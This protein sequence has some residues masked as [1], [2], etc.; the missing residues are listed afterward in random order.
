MEKE[1]EKL[2]MRVSA[3]S[4]SIEIWHNWHLLAYLGL[5]S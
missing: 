4:G 3:I 2:K 1:N 5:Q